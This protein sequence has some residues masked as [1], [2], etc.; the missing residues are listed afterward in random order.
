MSSVIDTPPC[1]NRSD[2]ILGCIGAQQ[3]PRVHVSQV[4]QLD[5]VRRVDALCG[6][7]LLAPP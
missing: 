3:D 1:P 6:V 7:R 4:V 2:T 5:L